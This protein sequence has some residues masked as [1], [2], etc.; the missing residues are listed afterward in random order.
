MT[1]ENDEN[2][3]PLK[4]F[5]LNYGNNR[6]IRAFVISRHGP[7]GSFLS[8]IEFNLFN[9]KGTFKGKQPPKNSHKE[10]EDGKQT[11]VKYFLL[12]S[13]I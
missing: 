9:I 5:S 6:Y 1:E 7:L 2:D 10:T 8:K 11:T 4:V 12:K 3:L 13:S